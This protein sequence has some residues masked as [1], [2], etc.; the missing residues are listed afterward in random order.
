MTFPAYK[1]VL[2]PGYRCRPFPWMKSL[3]RVLEKKDFV[4]ERLKLLYHEKG[5]F[6][7]FNQLP[8]ALPTCAVLK[9]PGICG[10]LSLVP[11]QFTLLQNVFEQVRK[12]GSSGK[13]LSEGERSML[14]A[15]REAGLR[16]KDAKEGA[17]IPFYAFYDTIREFLTPSVSRVIERASQN[18]KLKDDEFN[19]DLLKVLFMI[20]YI[21]ELPGNIDNLAT[22]MITHVD[23]DK[24]KLKEKIQAALQKLMSE[25]L[26]QKHGEK[27][28]FLTDD[29]QDINRE[30]K[31]VNI[32][33]DKVKRELANYIFQDLYD[34]RR[35]AYSK[36][37]SFPFNQ[38]MD[39]KNYGSQTASIGIHILSPLSEHYHKSDQELM[40]MS[41]GSGEMIVKLGGNESYVEEMEEALKI[42]TY[43]GR[44]NPLEFPENIQNILNNKQVEA[45][46]RRRRV[47]EQ[48]RTPSKTPPFSSMVKNW[49]KRLHRKGKISKGFTL[50]VENVYTKL[51]YIK[52][53]IENER[54]LQAVLSVRKTKSPLTMNC[55]QTE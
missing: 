2:T 16:Y 7:K 3:K 54:D 39:E 47:R 50:L 55:K 37:Y 46:E 53:H 52:E 48:L 29:E 36:E 35:F 49:N 17:L 33:E 28:I 25:T 4:H 15:F 26:I 10:S 40:M 21:K 43:R 22:L 51:H 12:H 34:V 24:L 41:S 9:A 18:P 44:R 14:S 5:H 32:E 6:E 23:E 8:T 38:K 27:Y 45:R 31:L 19:I 20:K 42:E 1:D 13:H 11:Y 30:I